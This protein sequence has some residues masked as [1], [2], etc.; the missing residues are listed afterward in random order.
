[1]NW[2]E[3]DDLLIR[4]DFAICR[5]PLARSKQICHGKCTHPCPHPH[6]LGIETKLIVGTRNNPKRTNELVRRSPP[7]EKRQTEKHQQPK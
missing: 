7:T 4:I 6:P 2:F 1:M 3:L 5:D